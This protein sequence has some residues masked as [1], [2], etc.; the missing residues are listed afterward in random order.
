[1]DRFCFAVIRS[2]LTVTQVW[3]P[4]VKQSVRCTRAP[5][6]VECYLLCPNVIVLLNES[7]FWFS[8][9]ELFSPKWKKHVQTTVQP[10]QEFWLFECFSFGFLQMK[11]LNICISPTS[12]LLSSI[13]LSFLKPFH[14][15]LLCHLWLRC[16]SWMAVQH[17]RPGGDWSFLVKNWRVRWRE[18]AALSGGC[19]VIKVC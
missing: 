16:M 6:V 7:S 19:E 13:K 1:M 2:Q 8:V 3:I 9:Q 11:H 10:L 14:C 18:I 4:G 15:L 17:V 5:S 12:V